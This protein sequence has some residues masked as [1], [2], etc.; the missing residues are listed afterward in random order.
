MT[1]AKKRQHEPPV[2]Y[3]IRPA[4][5]T[6]PLEAELIEYVNWSDGDFGL[7]S[8]LGNQLEKLQDETAGISTGS[9]AERPVLQRMDAVRRHRVV[10]RAMTSIGVHAR[11]LMQAYTIAKK[12]AYVAKHFGPW[13]SGIALAIVDD[14]ESLAIACRNV[15]VG[16]ADD[17]GAGAKKKADA[18]LIAETRR[19]T[20]RRYHQACK[21]YLVAIAEAKEQLVKPVA[22]RP[23]KQLEHVCR[24]GSPIHKC[25]CKESYEDS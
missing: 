18:R 9:D 5:L 24:V 22:P 4:V 3:T 16:Y 19:E 11:T 15:S 17:A 25:P 23:R 13:K 6:G 8:M 2:L 7:A 1:A 12:P 10:H 21:R 20:E 14:V